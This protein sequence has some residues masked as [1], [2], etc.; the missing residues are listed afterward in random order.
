M[1][2]NVKQ[3]KDAHQRTIFIDHR[4][5]KYEKYIPLF[6]KPHY[7]CIPKHGFSYSLSAIRFNQLTANLEK[8]NN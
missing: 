1:E 4:G 6:G 3:N 5:D 8:I 7:Q 2:R